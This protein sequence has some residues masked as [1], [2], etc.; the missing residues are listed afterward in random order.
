[1]FRND[2]LL[3]VVL[4]MLPT[5]VALASSRAC[6]RSAM[7]EQDLFEF[8]RL[9]INLSVPLIP[10][11]PKPRR[12]AL[13]SCSMSPPGRLTSIPY[14][15]NLSL[16]QL[17]MAESFP[18]SLRN[19]LVVEEDLLLVCFQ[20]LHCKQHHHCRLLQVTVTCFCSVSL[21]LLP[22]QSPAHLLVTKVDL[23]ICCRAFDAPF[24]P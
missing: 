7:Q 15:L 21:H 5:N 23:A 14:L 6:W 22:L 1:M 9:L 2:S 16:E 19:L 11:R 20:D 4:L 12:I 10:T 17:T 18:T 8:T 3:H 13:V 24:D